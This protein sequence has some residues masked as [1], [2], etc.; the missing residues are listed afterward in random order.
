MEPGIIP[1]IEPDIMGIDI[2][3]MVC[4]A[5]FMVTSWLDNEPCCHYNGWQSPSAEGVKADCA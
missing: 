3:G 4:A 2:M 1:G 5:G